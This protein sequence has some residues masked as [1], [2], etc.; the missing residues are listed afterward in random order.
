ML[1]HFHEP[2]AQTGNVS[3]TNALSIDFLSSNVSFLGLRA[4]FCSCLVVS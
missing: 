4:L 1:P 2:G 3:V